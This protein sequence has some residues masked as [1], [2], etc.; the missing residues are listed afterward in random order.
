MS[1][2]NELKKENK[3]LK[4]QLSK[5]L[6]AK[7]KIIQEY[8]ETNLNLQ[9]QMAP[10]STSLITDDSMLEADNSQDDSSII[11]D[12]PVN[13]RKR[14][15]GANIKN[16]KR[17]KAQATSVKKVDMASQ[18]SFE[19]S[20]SSVSDIEN[21]TQGQ[22]SEMKQRCSSSLTRSQPGRRTRG[23]SQSN[24]NSSSVLKDFTNDSLPL[25]SIIEEEQ[26]ET[27][28]RKSR[29]KLLKEA[30]TVEICTPPQDTQET[31]TPRTIVKRQLRSRK[32]KH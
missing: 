1:E 11:E 23:S 31:T 9:K 28:Q 7:D 27:P 22:S 2:I 12:T 19:D 15:K 14:R 4:D 21:E 29:R 5:D 3:K 13:S 8:H 25:T 24:T 10:S 20:I 30:E 26:R 32:K 18:A 17:K 6:K 16:N